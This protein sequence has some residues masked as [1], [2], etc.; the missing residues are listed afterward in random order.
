MG[1][2]PDV[3]YQIIKTYIYDI[4]MD[5]TFPTFSG[6]YYFFSFVLVLMLL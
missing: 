1:E 5:T 4:N 6:F 2:G 3:R